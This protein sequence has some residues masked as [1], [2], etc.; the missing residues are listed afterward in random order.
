MRDI[1]PLEDRSIE[2]SKY[3]KVITVIFKIHNIIYLAVAS[4]A[5]VINNADFDSSLTKRKVSDHVILD[6]L[7]RGKDML[8]YTCPVIGS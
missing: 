3:L 2:I 8:I 7:S 1:G 5:K 4:L 6:S